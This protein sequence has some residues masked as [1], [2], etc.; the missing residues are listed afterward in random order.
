MKKLVLSMMLLN[1]FS[2][3]FAGDCYLCEE[4]NEKNKKLPPLKYE[5]YDDYLEDLRRQG[6]LLP[7]EKEVHDGYSEVEFDREEEK[8]S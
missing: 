1:I 2:R 4:I 3:C 8:K 7:G 6:K 5:Y